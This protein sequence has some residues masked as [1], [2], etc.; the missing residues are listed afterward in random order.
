MQE[1]EGY[2][3]Q[4]TSLCPEEVV[5]TS[6]GRWRSDVSLQCL[7]GLSPEVSCYGVEERRSN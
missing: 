4:L 1:K 6:E 3:G 2:A 5:K 7:C